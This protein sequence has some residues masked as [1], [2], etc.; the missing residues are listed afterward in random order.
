MVNAH[1]AFNEFMKDKQ[2]IVHQ[3]KEAVRSALVNDTANDTVGTEQGRGALVISRT[4]KASHLKTGANGVHYVSGRPEYTASSCPHPTLLRSEFDDSLRAGRLDDF[5]TTYVVHAPVVASGSG[6]AHAHAGS[7]SAFFSVRVD[8]QPK[9]VRFAGVG[10]HYHRE[11]TFQSSKRSLTFA[12]GAS[13]CA[14]VTFLRVAPEGG[15]DADVWEALVVFGEWSKCFSKVV[16]LPRTVAPPEFDDVGTMPRLIARDG[17]ATRKYLSEKFPTVRYFPSD[18]DA[19]NDESIPYVK[20][21]LHTMV[22][23]RWAYAAVV[24]IGAAML[25]EKKQR[26]VS[27]PGGSRSTSGERAPTKRPV[28]GERREAG[29]TLTPTCKAYI[30]AFDRAVRAVVS[31]DA[32]EW[33]VTKELGAKLKDARTAAEAGGEPEMEAMRALNERLRAA[34]AVLETKREIKWKDARSSLPGIEDCAQ[35]NRMARFLVAAAECVTA[36]YDELLENA[37]DARA[38][39]QLDT[40]RVGHEGKHGY[41]HHCLVRILQETPVFM[42]TAATKLVRKKREVL[43]VMVVVWKADPFKLAACFTDTWVVKLHYCAYSQRYLNMAAWVSVD[44][45]Q[46]PAWAQRYQAG[47]FAAGYNPA[48][49]AA[50]ADHT[51]V[52]PVEMNLLQ[53]AEFYVEKPVRKVEAAR[54]K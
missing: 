7:I 53:K 46:R 22:R 31:A 38:Q 25:Y 37:P 30:H 3:Y 50:H 42:Q 18:A 23:L 41:G 9:N 26:E 13:T 14:N 10:T 27:Q 17:A 11:M 34:M 32:R 21:L 8:G 19:R 24:S 1:A 51:A 52:V 2:G 44:G 45:K 15:G 12:N 35:S 49:H 36:L 4:Y 40:L 54:N 28:A 29:Q 43:P 20:G 39:E 6:A 47:E 16:L 48:W 5:L 33:K